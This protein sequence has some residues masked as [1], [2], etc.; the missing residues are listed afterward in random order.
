MSCTQDTA[1]LHIPTELHA[2]HP[3]PLYPAPPP[4]TSHPSPLVPPHPL[5]TTPAVQPSPTV[6]VGTPLTAA[7]PVGTALTAIGFGQY[8]LG[9]GQV[10]YLQQVRACYLLVF[11]WLQCCSAARW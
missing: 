11:L 6:P 10:K 8:P 4:L 3:S 2:S 7:V 9:V 5:H 1:S